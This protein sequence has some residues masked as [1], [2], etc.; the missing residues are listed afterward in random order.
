MNEMNDEAIAHF[1]EAPEVAA[2]ADKL[3]EIKGLAR[4]ARQAE[5]KVAAI[6]LELKQCQD[7]VDK[8]TTRDLP[9]KMDAIGIRKITVEAIEDERAFTV[10]VKTM[11][12][13]NI[14]A[15]WDQERRKKAFEWLDNHGHGSLIKTDVVTTFPRE[16]RVEV[17]EFVRA[18]DQQGRSYAVKEA[19]HMATLSSW[20][21]EMIEHGETPPL[22]VIGGY[23]ERQATIKEERE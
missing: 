3:A 14:A 1:T 8:I 10:S 9:E 18:L 20:L 19:V 13:A 7:L 22:D 2:T 21:R 16:D 23:V 4:L 12:S 17:N 11:Y 15:S 6:Q 5:K